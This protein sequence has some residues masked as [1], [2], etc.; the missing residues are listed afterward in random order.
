VSQAIPIEFDGNSEAVH[1]K[2]WT[3]EG[4]KRARL[5]GAKYKLRNLLAFL[6]GPSSYNAERL[7]V[8]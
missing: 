5:S 2:Y 7:A 1:G 3:S 4:S 8:R 6:A